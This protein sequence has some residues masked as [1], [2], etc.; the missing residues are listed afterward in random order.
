M[1]SIDLNWHRYQAKE[2]FKTEKS[3]LRNLQ[4]SSENIDYTIYLLANATDNQIK[5][6]IYI[7]YFVFE[8]EI[9]ISRSTFK[10]IPKHAIDKF[11][12]YKNQESNILQL[13]KE[14]LMSIILSF[15]S[16]FPA[17]VKPILDK[18]G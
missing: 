6:A 5:C 14:T 12:Q 15:K 3:F 16:I 13:P 2:L 17:V 18:N 4:D 10:I 11:L 8:K 1:S 9:P 7:L